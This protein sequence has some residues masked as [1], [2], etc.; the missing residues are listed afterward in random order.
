MTQTKLM[1]SADRLDTHTILI[2]GNTTADFYDP[3]ADII[4]R[5]MSISAPRFYF[6][7]TAIEVNGTTNVFLY[8]GVSTTSGTTYLSTVDVYNS[9]T[10][11][12]SLTRMSFARYYHTVTKLPNGNVIIAGGS[13]AKPTI[14]NSLEMYNSS[15]NSFVNLT[16]RMSSLRYYHSATYIPSLQSILF[17]GGSSTT[18][19]S[20]KTFELFN[21]TTLKFVRNGTLRETRTAH[22]ATLLNNEQV[23]FVGGDPA[24]IA[25]EIF[26]PTT[27][28]TRYAANLS[29]ARSYHSATLLGNSGQVLICGGKDSGVA[30]NS[31]EIYYP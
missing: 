11:S 30:V 14:L 17:A 31:C 8:G 10:K 13:P 25:T 24:T 18:S 6:T 28:T 16:A 9:S 22:T 4:N 29:V 26:D 12:F 3:I 15:S 2:A 5:T 20:L 21:V 7:S 1:H 19:N 23:L 27:F